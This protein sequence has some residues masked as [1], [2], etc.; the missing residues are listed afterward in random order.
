MRTMGAAAI[1]LLAS[2]GV[3]TSAE[4]PVGRLFEAVRRGDTAAVGVLLR[5]GVSPDAGDRSGWTVL[6][7]AVA[8]DDVATARA[9]LAAGATPDLRSREGGTPLDLAERSGRTR[10]VRL[11]RS[12]GA[13]GSGKSVG[14]TVCV[15]L[16]RGDGYCGTV[17][18]VEP[19]HL[20]VRVTRL[21]GCDGGCS[22]DAVCSAGRPVGTG[23]LQTG[24]H[25]RIPFSCLTHTAVR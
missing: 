9:L 16:W 12:H 13:R 1:L 10:L 6:H 24:D 21:V 23:G 11:L 5:E 19:V 8:R 15:R 2:A 3:P 4:D 22:A 20:A 17:A 25:L 18:A 7:E 14:D